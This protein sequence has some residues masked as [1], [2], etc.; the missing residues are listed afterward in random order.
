VELH[1]EVE[2]SAFG[3]DL[4]ITADALIEATAPDPW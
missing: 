2:L 3:I 1:G 4:G